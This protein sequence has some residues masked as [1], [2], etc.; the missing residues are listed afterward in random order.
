MIDTKDKWD[1]MTK[2]QVKRTPCDI[3]FA[4]YTLPEGWEFEG[5]ERGASHEFMAGLNEMGVKVGE[6][7]ELG[8]DGDVNVESDESDDSLFPMLAQKMF[9][10]S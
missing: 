6:P 9:G 5:K 7:D 4:S 3:C 10:E 8:P 2:R 1:E